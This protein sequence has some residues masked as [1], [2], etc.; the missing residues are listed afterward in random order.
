MCNV[1]SKI[2]VICGPTSS[3]KTSFALKQI[4]DR[5]AVLITVDSRHLYQGLPI[6]SGWDLDPNKKNIEYV[7]FGHF[8]SD[9]KANAVDYAKY[10]REIIDDNYDKKD[11][12]LVGGSGFYIQAI[13]HPEKIDLAPANPELRKKFELLPI[14]ELKEE[15]KKTSPDV[16]NSL[17]N[18]DQNNPRR[19]I[20]RLEILSHPSPL[21]KGG[22]R[23]VF[24]HPPPFPYPLQITRLP[25]PADHHDLIKQR[26]EKRLSTGSLDEVKE[27]LKEYPGQALPIYST[28]GVKQ[29][30]MFINGQITKEKMVSLWLTDELSYVRRQLTW[31]KKQPNIFWYDE[32][33]T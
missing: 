21:Y 9:E 17:N 32:S 24:S 26:I 33:K 20:R 25:V 27:L 6:T 2:S 28:I 18:S 19:L 1:Q 22:S 11:I 31:F 14:D 15:L 12:Y 7:G 29:I 8:K 30:I 10:V 3:G 23:G 13:I 4:G 16:F 5:K